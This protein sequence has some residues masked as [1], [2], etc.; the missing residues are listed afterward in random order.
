MGT[1]KILRGGEEVVDGVHDSE[2]CLKW[3]G[4]W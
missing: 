2:V 1:I 3:G 4:G